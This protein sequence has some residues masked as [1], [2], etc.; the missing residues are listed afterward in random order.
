MTF[1][2]LEG[3]LH[4][5]STNTGF[6]IPHYDTEELFWSAMSRLP[7]AENNFSLAA[8]LPSGVQLCNINVLPAT[9]EFQTLPGKLDRFSL[10][11]LPDILS[12]EE[13]CLCKYMTESNVETAK[14]AV[15][16]YNSV[17]YYK[18]CRMILNSI[19]P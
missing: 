10:E 15:F 19:P 7:I 14:R 8:P 13:L 2:I 1:N 3:A 6:V 16:K 18:V 5:I 9:G 4:A 12:N 11:S 17:D